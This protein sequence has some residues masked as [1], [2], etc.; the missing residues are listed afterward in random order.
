M[1]IL[2]RWRFTQWLIRS[3]FIPVLLAVV[4]GLYIIPQLSADTMN[5][6]STLEGV[7]QLFTSDAALLAGWIH[8]LAFDI[9]IGG[10]IWQNAQ[11]RHVPHPW[12]I[13]AYILTFL[14]GPLGLLYY[15]IVRLF[16]PPQITA[17]L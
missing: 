10:W 17:V 14:L 16:Y 15:V 13:P 1:I 3:R 2:P 5:N 11:G 12:L 8:Y 6:F 4:Y 9:F 7:R